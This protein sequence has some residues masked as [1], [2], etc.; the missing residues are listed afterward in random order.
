M[1]EICFD[2]YR[3]ISIV[4]KNMK[5]FDC[6]SEMPF[7]SLQ[8]HSVLN[9]KRMCSLI[10]QHEHIYRMIL[11]AKF[12]RRAMK[13]HTINIWYVW[14]ILD[15]NN[16]AIIASYSQL[17]MILCMH[18]KKQISKKYANAAHKLHSSCFFSSNIYVE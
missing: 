17:W 10:L 16:I 3:L 4:L 2:I 7:I 15:Y 8:K 14:Y 9:F 18:R 6:I 5:F 11:V 13:F 12:V 1:Y